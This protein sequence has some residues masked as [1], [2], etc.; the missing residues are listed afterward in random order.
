MI[1]SIVGRVFFDIQSKYQKIVGKLTT[2]EMYSSGYENG[3]S[4]G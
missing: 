4:A 2:T 1:S 3:E